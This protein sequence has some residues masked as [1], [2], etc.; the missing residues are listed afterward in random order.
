MND[1]LL[2]ILS[3]ELGDILRWEEECP[4]VYYLAVMPT[5]G[6]PREFYVTLE[7]A[8]ISQELR[9]MGR[10]VEDSHIRLF[11]FEA[12]DGAWAAVR[13]EILRY[14]TTHNLPLPN[15]EWLQ[16]AALYG[17]EHCPDYFGTYP[18]SPVTPWGYTLRYRALDNGIY[19]IETDQCVEVLAVCFPVWDSELPDGVQAIAQKLEHEGKMGYLYFTKQ[20]SCVAIFEL[21]RTRSELT[22]LGLIR[23]AELMNAIWK[24]H[25]EY[26]MGYNVQ[27]QA[28]LNDAL[29][30]LLYALGIADRELEGSVAHAIS[31]TPEAGTDFIGF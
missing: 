25:P 7:D 11:Q 15:G 14:K 2:N 9:A 27:E 13:Y 6:E 28:G 3:Y 18:V 26:A 24:Y 10:R 22:E 29:G 5:G 17:M 30:S 31:L 19:W 8:P 20:D 16:D 23:R 4:G 12:E 1:K 21:L